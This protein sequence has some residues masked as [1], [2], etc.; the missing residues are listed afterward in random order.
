MSRLQ[1]KYNQEIYYVNNISF[2]LD[3]EI[4]F[5]TIGLVFSQKDV[6]DQINDGRIAA[7]II[8][9][10][11]KSIGW[12]LYQSKLY[13]MTEEMFAWTIVIVL[14]SIFFEG[15]CIYLLN[16]LLKVVMKTKD[17]ENKKTGK[18]NLY[19][20]PS[21]SHSFSFYL[22]CMLIFFILY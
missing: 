12:E 7:E 20:F 21:P 13:L 17:R 16:K 6:E 22:I 15:I 1:D 14:I 10:P 5:K 3:M 2:K 18:V 11:T 4:F 19:R 8:G 9:L